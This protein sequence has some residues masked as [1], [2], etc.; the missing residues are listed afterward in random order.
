M[1][2]RRHIFVAF[3]VALATT[4]ACSSP[5]DLVIL[6]GRVIDPETGVDAPRNVGIRDGSVVSLG[7]EV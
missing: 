6:G 7:E 4:A 2:H 5:H 3:A 1:V